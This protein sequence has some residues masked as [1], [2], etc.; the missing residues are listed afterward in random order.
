MQEAASRANFDPLRVI[1]IL[2]TAPGH[3]YLFRC[4]QWEN[5]LDQATPEE[6]SDEAVYGGEGCM[7]WCW[8]QL[9]GSRGHAQL[10]PQVRSPM[11]GTGEAGMEGGL[12]WAIITWMARG[13]V[14]Q[15]PAPKP[16]TQ[17][18]VIFPP[19]I[20]CQWLPLAK[21]NGKPPGK[22][23]GQ[24]LGPR[25]GQRN[26]LGRGGGQWRITGT[27]DLFD[28]EMST[29]PKLSLISPCSPGTLNPNHSFP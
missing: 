10:G 24:P 15:R 16:H 25:K 26:E 1:V 28:Q 2:E 6:L 9:M 11:L 23:R 14:S 7:K 3:E 29:N 5:I 8:R 27:P 22:S 4:A 19:S 20:S 18:E 13:R 21:P 17:G 12:G